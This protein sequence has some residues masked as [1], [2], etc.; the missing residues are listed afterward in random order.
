MLT[1]INGLYYEEILDDNDIE[2]IQIILK[3]MKR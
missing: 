3:T 2:I 1:I